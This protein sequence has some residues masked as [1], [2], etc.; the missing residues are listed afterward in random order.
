MPYIF[1]PWKMLGGYE[2]GSEITVNGNDE[3][4][5]M[6]R[7]IDLQ[8]K[9]GALEY[10]TGVCDEYYISGEYTGTRELYL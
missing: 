3:A 8:E 5:C 6:Q 7:L 10:Y 1:Y 9:H 4:D 2:D